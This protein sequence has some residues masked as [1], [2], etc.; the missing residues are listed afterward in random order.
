MQERRFLTTTTANTRA[1]D[2]KNSA[3][4]RSLRESLI[5]HLL[6]ILTGPLAVPIVLHP[7]G[8]CN[9]PVPKT[10]VAVKK[11]A[12]QTCALSMLPLT[13]CL[14]PYGFIFLVVTCSY[15]VSKPDFKLPLLPRFSAALYGGLVLCMPCAP[16]SKKDIQIHRSTDHAKHCKCM[17]TW[18]DQFQTPIDEHASCRSCAAA[19]DFNVVCPKHVLFPTL[20]LAVHD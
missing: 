6:P 2:K 19:W 8:V 17:C 15:L 7:Q 5:L 10:I 4:A 14:T 13:P 1:N 18:E 11:Q 3:L 9:L 20:S 16:Q 12:L